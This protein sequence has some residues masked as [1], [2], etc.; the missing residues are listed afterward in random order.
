MYNNTCIGKMS[1]INL[2]E[3]PFDIES[4]FRA[5]YVNLASS[6]MVSK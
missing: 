6:D 3:Q 1:K 4:C 2:A 5:N